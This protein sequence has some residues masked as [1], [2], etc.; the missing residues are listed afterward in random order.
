MG[1]GAGSFDGGA[2]ASGVGGG[3]GDSISGSDVHRYGEEEQSSK[4]GRHGT[5]DSLPW[6]PRGECQFPN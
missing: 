1:P 3:V 5:T 4:I 6:L 2:D